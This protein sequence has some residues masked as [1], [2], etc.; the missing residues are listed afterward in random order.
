MDTETLKQHPQGMEQFE[1]SENKHGHPQGMFKVW[2]CGGGKTG[3]MRTQTRSPKI[4]LRVSMFT[5]GRSIS[6]TDRNK[7]SHFRGST[8][9][10]SH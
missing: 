7:R 10:I 1:T 9:S 3:K 5:M 4:A 2:V 6:S 8:S